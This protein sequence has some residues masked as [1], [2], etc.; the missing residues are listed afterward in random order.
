MGKINGKF[1]VLGKFAKAEFTHGPTPSY[2]QKTTEINVDY[3]M[4]QFKARLMSFVEIYRF[5]RERPNF[6]QA[7]IGLQV[8]I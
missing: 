7:G 8:Q 6:W 2:D 3:V 1:E 4:K 5:N